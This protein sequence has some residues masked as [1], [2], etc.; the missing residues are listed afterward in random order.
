MFLVTFP[1]CI[2]GQVWYLIVSIPD[3]CCLSYLYLSYRWK[4]LSTGHFTSDIAT[5]VFMPLFHKLNKSMTDMRGSRNF[6]QGGGHEHISDILFCPQLIYREI[7][8]LNLLTEGSTVNFEE[9]C[10]FPRFQRRPNIF[11]WV[12]PT[13]SRGGGSN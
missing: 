4:Q 2:L 6:H 3:F 11:Q 1:C 13:F 10:T 5:C 9:N 12:G 8:I 7:N